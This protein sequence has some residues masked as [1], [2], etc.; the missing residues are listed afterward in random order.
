MKLIKKGGH[1]LFQEDRETAEIVS[2]MLQDLEKDGMDAV[3]SSDPCE[4]ALKQ[5]TS[6]LLN[7]E[8]GRVSEGCGINPA[9]SGC[10]YGV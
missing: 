4:R 1:R 8:S 7:I 2:G 6:L 5:Y 10:G 3:P 9:K